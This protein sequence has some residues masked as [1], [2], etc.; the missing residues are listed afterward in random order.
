MIR[1]S[2]FKYITHQDDGSEMLFD[3]QSDPGETINLAA[4]PA[5]AVDLDRHRAMLREWILGLD[6]APNVP[7]ESRWFG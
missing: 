6:V 7:A 2:R 3:M 4:D 1:S 5:F